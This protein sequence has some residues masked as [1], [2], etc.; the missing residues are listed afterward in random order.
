MAYNVALKAALVRANKG[1][2]FT[3]RDLAARV[4]IVETRMSQIMTG[5]VRPSLDEQRRIAKGLNV[6]VSE[7]FPQDLEQAS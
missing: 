7:V 2:G 1:R 5:H 3:Q 6:P 4:R